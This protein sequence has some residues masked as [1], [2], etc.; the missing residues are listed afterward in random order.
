MSSEGPA[1]PHGEDPE[2]NAGT[3]SGGAGR[4]GSAGLGR[5][6]RWL[7]AVPVHLCLLPI[8]FYR[9]FV[10]PITPATCRFQPTCSAYAE[11]ALRRRGLFV[12]LSLSVW[13]V[14]R[15]QPFSAGGYDP[16]PPRRPD[17]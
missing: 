17:S 15:C 12:G 7:I 14:L 2:V 3:G 11:E 8:R 13:R 1:K 4:G 10:S 6:V 16:V 9:R 5:I